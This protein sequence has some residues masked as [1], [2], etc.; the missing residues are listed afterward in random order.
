MTKQRIV[1]IDSN[2]MKLDC[3]CE[4]YAPYGGCWVLR[5]ACGLHKKLLEE[6]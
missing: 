4:Y 1:S 5:F 3:G 6:K 2:T